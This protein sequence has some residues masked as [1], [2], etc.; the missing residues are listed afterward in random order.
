MSCR[1]GKADVVMLMV[2]ILLA[3]MEVCRK[4]ESLSLMIKTLFRFVTRVLV[5]SD[6]VRRTGVPNFSF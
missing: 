2:K 3:V 6:Q 1:E 4:D 5:C